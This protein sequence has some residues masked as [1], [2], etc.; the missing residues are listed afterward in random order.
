[1]KKEMILKLKINELKKEICKNKILVNALNK[2]NNELE[3]FVLRAIATS[4]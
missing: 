2:K 1:M 4:K 3:R